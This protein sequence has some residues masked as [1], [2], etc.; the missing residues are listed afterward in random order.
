M[1]EIVAIAVAFPFVAYFTAKL[2]TYGYLAAR[3]RFTKN[4]PTTINPKQEEVYDGE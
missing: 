3:H 2:A 1:I 4:H